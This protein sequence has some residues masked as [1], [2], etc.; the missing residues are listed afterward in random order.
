[1]TFN[2][3]RIYKPVMSSGDDAMFL[4]II[5]ILMQSWIGHSAAGIC[6]NTLHCTVLQWMKLK[7]G[8]FFSTSFINSA[9][10]CF[11]I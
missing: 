10:L 6:M 1:M 2:I 3:L 7:T 8:Y 11:F 9:V 4:V 5:F